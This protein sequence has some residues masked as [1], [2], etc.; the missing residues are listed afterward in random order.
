MKATP[1]AA[2]LDQV[3]LAYSPVFDRKLGVAATRLTVFAVPGA[4][5][6]DGAALLNALSEA[7]DDAPSQATTLPSVLLNVAHEAALDAVLAAAQREPRP[8]LIEVPAFLAGSR[9]PRLQALKQAGQVMALAS[10]L[11][12]DA[13]TRAP[14]RYLSL[15]SAECA[16]MKSKSALPLPWLCT[17]ARSSAELDAALEQGAQA[18]AGW[19]M[20]DEIVLAKPAGV[21]PEVRGIVELMNRLER[22]E[23]PERLEAV[24][25][26]D[27][28]LAF[29]LLR[30]LNS[31]AFGLRAEVTSFKHGLMMLGHKRLKRWLA[32]LLASG[33]PNREAR[34]LMPVAA[35]RGLLLD[36]LA[37][38]GGDESMRAEMFICGVF[39]LIDRMLRQPMSVLMANLPVQDRVQ[40]SLTAEGGPY[41]QY[42]DLA[43]ALEQGAASDI[44]AAAGAALVAR[45]EVNRALLK[46]LSLARELD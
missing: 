36:E 8:F 16:Q 5:P 4:G 46:A 27:P 1:V 28:T 3:V 38:S 26:S 6:V 13:A 30:Y 21:P 23:P 20:D 44:S 32:L 18:V 33:S 37:R 14:F 22:E 24:L 39:S 7:F 17:A 34:V 42:L 2:V 35:R 45:S 31:S 11:Q 9:L 43:R 41:G 19:P 12:A 25:T 29:R 10:G 15:S 40:K